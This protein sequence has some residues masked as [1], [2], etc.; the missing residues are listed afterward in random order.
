MAD[1]TI[2]QDLRD[3]V[4]LPNVE[5]V[6]IEASE[7]E[8]YRSKKFRTLLGAIATPNEDSDGYTNV[9]VSGQVATI[10]TTSGADTTM[11]L[12]L[13]GRK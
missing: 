9:V 1:V 2:A 7:G 11:T 3:Y 13:F 8:E 5:V 6:Q 10:H 12:M 4:H